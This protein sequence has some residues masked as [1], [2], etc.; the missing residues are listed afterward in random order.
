MRY[1]AGIETRGK[2]LEATRSLIAEEGLEGT[3]IKAICD[4][5]GVL[6]GSFYNLFSSK[7]E[8]ILSVVRE[9]ID[10][11]DPDPSHEGPDDL[12]ALV[13]AYI[14]FLEEQDDVARVYIR[15]AVAG[16]RNNNGEIKGRVLRHHEGR[17]K[18]FSG[19][20]QSRDRTIS[21]EQAERRA[22]TLVTAL[23]GIALHRVI[24]PE[25]DV[26]FH[27]RALLEDI[28]PPS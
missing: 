18:R 5:A 23:N 27:A 21:E 22:E 7:E 25:F 12:D 20:L 19:A 9:A 4:R 11:V 10:A 6:P 14:R 17:V 15:I 2:I 3:T 24:D 13:D 16:A 8:A 26:G 28:A 1:K